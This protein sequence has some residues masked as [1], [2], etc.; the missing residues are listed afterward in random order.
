MLNLLRVLYQHT[1]YRL[2]GPVIDPIIF[3][4][5]RST[6]FVIMEY[7]GKN[8]KFKA[9]PAIKKGFEDH[10]PEVII[11]DASYMTIF[12]RLMDAYNK[13]KADQENVTQPYQVGVNWQR[14]IDSSCVDLIA[15]L[16]SEDTMKLQALLEN[17]CRER[18][19]LGL[20]GGS[21]YSNM[22]KKP[23]YKYLFVNTW[24]KYYH[25][26]E[27]I[28]GSPPQLT[29]PMVGNPVGLYHDGQ[30]IPIEAIHFH[31]VATEI[32]SLLEDVDN[33]VVCEIGGGVGG[34][35]YAI[36]SNSG[37]PIT[38]ILLDIPEVLVLAS[39]FLMAALPEKKFLLYGEGQLDS[40]K[41]VQYDIILMPNF[42]LPQLGDETVDLFFNQRSFSE[43][44]SATVEEY[45]CQ[46]ERIC[47]RYFMHINHN[48]KFVWYDNGKETVNLPSIQVRPSPE[49]FKKVYQHPWLFTRLSDEINYKGAG[50]LAFLYERRRA[51][52]IH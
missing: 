41:M 38:Y 20:D 9:M 39:Y 21:D 48:T 7:I 47:R 35:A 6:I 2:F 52:D 27:E 32:L 1:V 42:V 44:D 13:A 43:M 17:F 33:A 10:R 18:F 34:Q 15:A 14:E 51:I 26:Y 25:L 5:V 11:N 16:R 37:R 24:Y 40:N 3:Y 45:L 29:Y 31:Y 23:L 22:K 50:H 30:V 19:G 28:M 46:I 4:S 36:L 12:K 8:R 49:R